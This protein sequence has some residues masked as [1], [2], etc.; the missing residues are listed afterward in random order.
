[1]RLPSV[2]FD[3]DWECSRPPY[4]SEEEFSK[5]KVLAAATG[6]AVFANNAYASDD[7]FDR[8]FEQR[9]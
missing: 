3:I 4:L 1:M 6:S 9:Y 5:V 7:S 8:G 2:V